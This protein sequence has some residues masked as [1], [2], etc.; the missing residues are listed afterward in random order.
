MAVLQRI[1]QSKQVLKYLDLN[2]DLSKR[3]E[4]LKVDYSC[5]GKTTLSE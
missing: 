1:H 3:P 4:F 5:T 2:L